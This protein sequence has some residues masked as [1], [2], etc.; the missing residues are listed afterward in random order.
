MELTLFLIIAAVTLVITVSLLSVG[1]RRLLGLRIGKARAAFAS[2]AALGASA[3]IGSAMGEARHTPLVSV[4]IGLT[5]LATVGFLALS[6]AMVPSGSLSGMVRWPRQIRDRLAR[7]RRYGQLSRI[8]MRHGLGDA[9]RGRGLQAPEAALGRAH[10]ARRLRLALEDGGAT[11]VKL[12]QVLSTRYDLLPP[13]FVAELTKLQHQVT[14]D[15]WEEVKQVL[16]AELGREPETFFAEFDPEP[17][18]AGSIAQVHRAR[19]ATGEEVA[20]KVQRPGA[21]ELVDLDLDILFRVS[22]KIEEHTSWGRGLGTVDLAEGF[23]LSLHEELDFRIEARNMAA[24]RAAAETPEQTSRM[25]MPHVHEE[26]S[27]KRVLVLE[28]LNGTPLNAAGTAI[29]ERGLDRAEL[30]RQLMECILEQI[31]IGGVFHADPHPGNIMLM[32][33]GGLGLLDFGS[34][35]R[36]SRVLREALSKLLLAIDRGDPVALSDAL[37]ELV[38]RGEDTDERLLERDLGRFMARHLTPGTR[39][40]TEM[41]S[42]LFRL[43]ARHGLTVP[44]EIAATF[45][46]L[47]TMEGVMTQL[48]PGADIIA[49]ART[50]ATAQMERK[51]RPESIGRALAEE[52]LTLAPVLRRLPRRI[53]RITSDLE[54]GKLGVQVRLLADGRDRHFVRSLVHDV[55]LAFLGGVTALVGVLLLGIGQGPRIT[56][57]LPLY[58]L[59]G[60]HVLLVSCALVLRVVFHV[61]RAPR[62]G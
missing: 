14:P 26:V 41:F 46:A 35:G 5:L 25:R 33:D 37:L 3:L 10:L 6:E 45:R 15:P 32:Q 55:V 24:I 56:S 23:A 9:L 28:W 44:P 36:I 34:V 60:Y 40:D 20:V 50:F 42:D 53:E 22:R 18:A 38:D 21:Q 7:T 57:S 61:F 4:Q 31:M 17:L 62:H 59:M 49:E 16:T 30:V 43:V 47:A 12:G 11:F 8:A 58:Q 2:L 13:E 51:L 29:E 19:L 54:Q 48:N 39:P 52:A 27:G 1:A